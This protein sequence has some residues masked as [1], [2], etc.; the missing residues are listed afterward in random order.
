MRWPLELAIPG[1]AAALWA[2]GEYLRVRRSPQ[3]PAEKTA[4]RMLN[5]VDRTARQWL[6]RPERA[7]QANRLS[8][9]LAYVAV[10]LACTAALYSVPTRRQPFLADAL[11]V[12]RA[13]TLAGAVNQVIKFVAPRE[14]PFAAETG[15]KGRDRY[16]SFF[17][18]HT[19][20]V[21]AMAAATTRLACW[22]GARMWYGAPL[23]ALAL[24]VGLL[25]IVSDRHYLTD[26][27]A[28]AAFGTV[29]G[30][31]AAREF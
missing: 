30:V 23:F 8:D 24:F 29:A 21:S 14:R 2:G 12:T 17:S 20:A 18:N 16:G 31:A 11:R 13:A 10:P 9:A 7:E 19:S 6:L 28:G 4:N 15:A 26:V 5:T 3:T 1:G 22:R 25:R 27:L